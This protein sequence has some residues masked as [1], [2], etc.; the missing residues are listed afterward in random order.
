VA[1]ADQNFSN[2]AGT[3][4]MPLMNDMDMFKC[5]QMYS[6]DRTRSMHDVLLCP[7]PHAPCM[8]TRTTRERIFASTPNARQQYERV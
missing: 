6:H 7:L 3:C 4:R 1:A 5:F 8:G 2:H